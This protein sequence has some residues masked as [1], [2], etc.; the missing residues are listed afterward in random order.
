MVD[1]D[2]M[3]S[4][5]FDR[6]H[7]PEPPA[8]TRLDHTEMTWPQALLSDDRAGL[9]HCMRL[10]FE[11]A[12]HGLIGQGDRG[13]DY[14]E[15]TDEEKALLWQDFVGHLDERVQFISKGVD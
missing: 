2:G 1:S 4:E 11:D 14:R 10:V 3:S 5:E 8:E 12:L 6:L 15:L 9:A 7:P 13:Y